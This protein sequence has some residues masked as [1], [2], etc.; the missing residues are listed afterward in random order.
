VSQIKHPSEPS[1][2]DSRD[3]LA[4]LEDTGGDGYQTRINAVLREYV[5]SHSRRA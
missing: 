1:S 5:K 3:E 4:A 2:Q